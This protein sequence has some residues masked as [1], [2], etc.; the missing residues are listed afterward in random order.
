MHFSVIS[1]VFLS[2]EHY[3]VYD[4][5][6]SAIPSYLF[7]SHIPGHKKFCLPDGRPVPE[8]H[9]SRQLHSRNKSSRS[10]LMILSLCCEVLF[11]QSVPSYLVK[12]PKEDAM[13]TSR[14]SKIHRK[15]RSAANL[16]IH[17]SLSERFYV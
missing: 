8:S 11:L 10:L 4:I 1:I 14:P 6:Y 3:S 13:C 16:E 5:C 15:I 17:N 9:N 7:S 2:T 12:C